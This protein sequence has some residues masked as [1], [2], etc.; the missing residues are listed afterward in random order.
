MTRSRDRHRLGRRVL[1]GRLH[2]ELPRPHRRPRGRSRGT[3]VLG[4]HGAR[5]AGR[6]S[7]RR[8]A[9]RSRRLRPGPRGRVPEDANGQAV[10]DAAP[11]PGDPGVP[12][13]S[14]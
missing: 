1:P 13:R 2:V 11:G 12:D 6:V 9:D 10:R 4:H 3:R 5:P 8:A 7:V 14:G